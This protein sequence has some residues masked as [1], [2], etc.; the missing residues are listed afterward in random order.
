MADVK[1]MLLM[2][3]LLALGGNLFETV[4]AAAPSGAVCFGTAD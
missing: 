1:G 2:F 3:A 4:T